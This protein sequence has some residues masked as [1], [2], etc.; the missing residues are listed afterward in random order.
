V[1]VLSKAAW[2]SKNLTLKSAR[3]FRPK[4]RSNPRL[5]QE[6]L[7]D[8]AQQSAGEYPPMVDAAVVVASA[9]EAVLIMGPSSA[10]RSS[11]SNNNSSSSSSSSSAR[12][13][14]R[15]TY[16]HGRSRVLQSHQRCL[17]LAFSYPGFRLGDSMLCIAQHW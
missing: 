10:S 13:T 17:D 8:M 6:S 15:V 9:I 14:I 7:T 11:N 16:R 2:S 5:T 3:V 4:V 12:L 1:G